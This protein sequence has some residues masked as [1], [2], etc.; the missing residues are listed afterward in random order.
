MFKKGTLRKKKK[1]RAAVIGGTVAALLLAAAGVLYLS[2]YASSEMDVTL[3]DIASVRT[4]STLYAYQPSERPRRAGELHP[5]PNA[6][7]AESRP[8]IYV[9]YDEMPPDLIN[10][11]V[12]IEDKRF[13]SHSGVDILRTARA[14]AR[15]LGGNATFG[16]STITQQLIKNVTGN[17]R[18]TLDRKLTEIFRALDLER[19]VDKTRIL[20]AYLNIINLADGCY[21]VGAAA[22]RYFSKSVSELT[23][24]ECAAIAAITNNPARYNPLTHPE[25]NCERRNIIL[26]EMAAQGYITEE[27]MYGALQSP[28]ELRP[29]SEAE[30]A[31]PA[32]WYADMVVSD[33]IRDLR[34]RLG[35]TYEAASLLVYQGGLTIETAMDETLQRVVETYYADLANFPIG[36]DGRPQSSLILIDP[37]TGDILAVAGAVGLKN[38]NRLQNYATDTRRP[39]GSCI[40]PLT[41]YAPALQE[42]LISWSSLCEDSP[43]FERN[44]V[45]WPANADGQYRGAVTVAQAVADSLNPVAVRILEQVG[46]ANALSFARDRLGMTSLLLPDGKR[47][48][49]QTLASLALGQHSRGVTVR[50]LTAAY[51][52]FSDGIY[53]PALSY[54]RVLD[55]E[56]RVLL[57]NPPASARVLTEENAALMT[58]LLATVTK[59]GTAAR[60]MTLTGVETAGKT[61]TTQNNCD[62]WF[63]GY[64]PRLLAGVWMGYDYPSEL[65]GI[66]GNPCVTI[67]NEIM[68]ICETLYDGSSAKSAFDLP[69]TL[70]EIEFCPASGK[71]RGPFCDDP[72]EGCE[73]CV[74]WFVRGTEPD[75][76]CDVHAE[77]PVRLVPRDPTDPDR[78]PLLRDDLIGDGVGDEGTLR[79]PPRPILPRPFRNFFRRRKKRG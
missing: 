2:P 20:E 67:W 3:L 44:G 29:D 33:V 39:A 11:F 4:P 21:G 70:V 26:R 71:L 35:Y 78:I 36:E 22:K 48:N 56:G 59:E 76:I 37:A 49:D 51:T 63:V 12:A 18:H 30:S 75:R 46:L 16:G 52:V 38:A 64:T 23:L 7:L 25:Q 79:P 43:L 42:G 17:D 47:E 74:G 9:P 32:S 69:D 8:R 55:G 73:A 54:H 57:E 53:R 5:A 66:Y 14:G 62:R 13:W 40:K 27:E 50:E 61:G 77:P 65:K 1:R 6:A 41:V 58:K 31:S 28:A 60:A 68:E 34:E 15:Y 10:A 24:S 72:W 19:K 45:P